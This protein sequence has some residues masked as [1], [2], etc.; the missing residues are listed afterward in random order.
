MFF[1]LAKGMGDFRGFDLRSNLHTKST[2][3][4][5]VYAGKIAVVSTIQ[6]YQMDPENQV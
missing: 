1:A 5:E 3:F 6:I 2:H 4:S